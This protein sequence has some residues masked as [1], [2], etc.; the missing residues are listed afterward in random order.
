MTF[1]SGDAFEGNSL[2]DGRNILLQRKVPPSPPLSSPLGCLRV[3]PRGRPATKTQ[4]TNR[5]T[6][7]KLVPLLPNAPANFF[8]VGGVR[9]RCTAFL[10]AN[11][12][13]SI[14]GNLTLQRLIVTIKKWYFKLLVSDADI[15]RVT[16]DVWCIA[17][18]GT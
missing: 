16:C 5:R 9:C 3:S 11:G 10:L 8:Y 7:T 2:S 15:A 17:C 14:S 18:M 12:R 6:A 4:A 13:T 1:F